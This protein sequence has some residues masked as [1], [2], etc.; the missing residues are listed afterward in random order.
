MWARLY[1]TLGQF[2]RNEPA[3]AFVQLEDIRS[4]PAGAFAPVFSRVGLDLTDAI[5]TEL[6]R[7]T[8][9]GT[10]EWR[11]R[12]TRREQRAIRDVVSGVAQCHYPE[13]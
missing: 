8:R 13:W 3:M 4:D 7:R 12:L 5:R 10:G 11:D 2:V 1:R 9:P 6:I